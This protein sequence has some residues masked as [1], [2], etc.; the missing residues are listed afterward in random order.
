MKKLLIGFFMLTTLSVSAQQWATYTPVQTPQIQLPG[1]S[2]Q[3]TVRQTVKEEPKKEVYRT[4]GY[5]EDMYG[6]VSR[7]SIKFTVTK[8]YTGDILTIV[9]YNNGASW[10]SSNTSVYKSD[11]ENFD[12]KAN[13]L[14]VGTVYFNF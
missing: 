3:K 7:T 11:N 5:S 6:K 4:V 9:S 2:Q 8:S 12:Y 1:Q 13:L 14:N 10:V